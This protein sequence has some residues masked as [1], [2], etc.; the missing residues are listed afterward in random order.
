MILQIPNI[1]GEFQSDWAILVFVAI[2]SIVALFKIYY[3]WK[4]DKFSQE[5]MKD[6]KAYLK[7]LSEHYTEEVSDRQVN[8][9]VDVGIEHLKL[10]IGVDVSKIM[11]HNNIR[12]VPDM[13]GKVRSY[14]DNAF[15]YFV[16]N[17][18]MYRYKGNDIGIF[19]PPEYEGHV[20]DYCTSIVMKG[21]NGCNEIMVDVSSLSSYLLTKFTKMKNK[22]MQNIYDCR[23]KN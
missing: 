3:D 10:R 23:E 5:T 4:R 19:I 15:R 11:M 21:R 18:G 1:E 8:H 14:I 6:I 20:K 17:M 12:D 2:M 22:T 9:I 13:E 16:L 7:I